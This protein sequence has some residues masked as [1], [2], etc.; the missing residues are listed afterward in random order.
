MEK[1]STIVIGGGAAGLFF[2]ATAQ[3][4]NKILLLERNDRLGKK[5]SA[6]GNGQGN[7]KI[8]ALAA[9]PYFSSKKSGVERAGGLVSRFDDRHIV[10]FFRALGGAVVTDE[11]GRVYPAGRQ[12]S[13]ITDLLRYR[14]QER[15][16]EVRLG[17]FVKRIERS[18]EGFL[19][20]ASTAEG[21]KSFLGKTVLLCTGGKAAKNFGTDGNGYD[22]AK[23]FG[24]SVTPLF[25]SLVQLKTDTRHTKGLK[26]LRVSD[27]VVSARV[28]GRLLAKV[29]GDLIFTDYGVSGDAIFR[30]SA[31]LGG[32]TDAT[33][34]VDLIP[35]LTKEELSKA[36]CA[37]RKAFPALPESELFCGVLNNQLG[38]AV[39]K[40]VGEGDFERLASAAKSFPI[41][42]TGSLGFDYA[43]VTKG[44]VPLDEVDED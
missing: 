39:V 32:K 36:L 16:V 21:E 14:V 23:S 7:L 22:L 26:G 9:T 10:A 34:F 8:T 27:A 3:T 28:D 42:V 13:A 17:A 29:Q 44:G 6:T 37:K 24:H 20:T 12:A 41:A 25:P 38:R 2:C 33:L 30:L 15:G 4:N 35:A 43:Q 18:G 11:R 40:F 19:V 1:F 31:F 5:L